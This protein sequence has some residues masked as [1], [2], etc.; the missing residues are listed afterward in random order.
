M[1]KQ[2]GDNN[3]Y[4]LIIEELK[5][6]FHTAIVAGGWSGTK[7]AKKS[8]KGWYSAPKKISKA[9]VPEKIRKSIEKRGK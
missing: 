5:N 1:Q 4:G 3:H 8:T 6:G 9:D 7:A 2:S